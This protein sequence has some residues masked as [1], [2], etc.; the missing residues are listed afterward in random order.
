MML[1]PTNP[2]PATRGRF[3]IDDG[4]PVALAATGLDAAF[5]YWRGASRARFVFSVS[6]ISAVRAA[7]NAVVVLAATG[8]DGAREAVWIGRADDPEFSFARAASI[9]AGATEAH[10]HVTQT[11]A[12][13]QRIARDLKAAV[14]VAPIRISFA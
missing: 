14:P 1:N 11:Q 9:A 5:R 4:T 6:P 13:A 7:A 3:L 2:E 12:G 8:K 10:V